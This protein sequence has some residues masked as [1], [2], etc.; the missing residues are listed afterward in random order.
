MFVQAVPFTRMA[1][2]LLAAVFLMLPTK[3]E[4]ASNALVST[5]WLE[6]NLTR[7]DIIIID[8]RSKMSKSGKHDYLKGHIPGAIWSEYPGFWRTER[9]GIVGVLPSIEKLEASLSALGVS[10]DKTLVIVPAGTSSSE[11][12]AAARIFWTMKY[13]GHDA[14]AILDGG[15]AA[16]VAE[17]RP[18][19]TGDVQPEG[20]LFVANVR[21]DLLVSTSQVAEA[22]GTPAL[23]LDGR[24]EAQFS[25]KNKHS[26]ATRFGHIPGAVN[27]DQ[28]K[29]YDKATNR[30]KTKDD[31]ASLLPKPVADGDTPII[32]Y[33]NTGHWA[34]TNWFVL[35]QVLGKQNVSLYDDSMVG[36]TRDA[37]LPIHATAVPDPIKKPKQN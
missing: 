32:S 13:L 24:P 3:V 29:F 10:E 6:E 23:L 19:E 11:F 35:T 25:G 26:K 20:N 30:L 18:L 17:S 1:A 31:L 37:A 33:C 8:T 28:A 5:T 4:A 36:W 34:A 14:V 7:D 15:H 27:F 9:D 12:G 16:W 2:A 21:D 22:M